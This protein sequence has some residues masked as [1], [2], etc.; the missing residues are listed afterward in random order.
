MLDDKSKSFEEIFNFKI[1]TS[2]INNSRLFVHK[3]RKLKTL[4]KP[5]MFFLKGSLRQMMTEET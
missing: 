5:V 3:H 1:W 2:L 4:S